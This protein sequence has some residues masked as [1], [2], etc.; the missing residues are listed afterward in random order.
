MKDILIL[1]LVLV[2]IINLLFIY[3]CVKVSKKCDE[4][5]DKM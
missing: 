1:F 5:G 3:S 2:I 4:E